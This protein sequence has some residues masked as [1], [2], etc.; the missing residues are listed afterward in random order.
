MKDTNSLSHTKWECKYH[1]VSIPKY[2][3]GK[4]FEEVRR[5]LGPVLRE[6]AQSVERSRYYSYRDLAVASCQ[7]GAF[8][9]A[10]T[11]LQ[12]A[13]QHAEQSGDGDLVSEGLHYRR[14]FDAER[15]EE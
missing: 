14:L 6:L 8:E 13:L 3:R 10:R 7:R 2:R 9:E 12:T 1:V 15:C 11:Y 4:L 5:E